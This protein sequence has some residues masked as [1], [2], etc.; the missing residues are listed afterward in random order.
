MGEG[1]KEEH[2]KKSHHIS[3]QQQGDKELGSDTITE[4]ENVRPEK[5]RKKK[6]SEQRTSW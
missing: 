5:G 4:R 2:A 3:P 6:Y 1:T